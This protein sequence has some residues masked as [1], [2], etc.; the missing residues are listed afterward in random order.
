MTGEWL[1][2]CG[3]C[4]VPEIANVFRRARIDFHQITG[5]LDDD[6]VCWNEVD[7]WIDAARVAHVMFAQP[8]RRDGPL[9]RRDARHLLGPDA[10]LRDASAATS[11]C[12]KS[13]S[14]RR[15]AA[16]L[17]RSRSTPASRSSAS[18]STCSRIASSGELER[19]ARTSVA[20]DRLVAEHDLGFSRLLL[21]GRRRCR[22]RGC[23]ELDHPGQLAADRAWHSGRR[24]VRSQ[25]RPGDEDPRHFRCRRVV[26]RVLRDGLRPTTSS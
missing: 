9:L 22:E 19:A 6:P 20:L 7:A 11:R 15:S 17:R 12:S 25:E 8:A 23:D 26:H 14:S 13:T 16:A 18:C 5:M 1:A 24:R 21:Q 2:Y 10:A 4:P 3:A